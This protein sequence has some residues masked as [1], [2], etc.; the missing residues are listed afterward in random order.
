ML[1]EAGESQC[2]MLSTSSS[3]QLF[4][5][6]SN[7]QFVTDPLDLAASGMGLAAL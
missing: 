7:A 5:D 2:Q 3:R 1:S 4:K 6:M